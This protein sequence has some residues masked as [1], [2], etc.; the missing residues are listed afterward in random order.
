[1]KK[2]FSCS[3]PPTVQALSGHAKPTSKS[4]CAC[5]CFLFCFF[6]ISLAFSHTQQSDT[7]TPTSSS[8][9]QYLLM[10]NSR[11]LCIRGNLATTST[12]TT[13]KFSSSG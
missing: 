3:S 2:E 8:K 11:T 10:P 5:V 12:T 1:M 4:V 7:K 13:T 6:S 9:G